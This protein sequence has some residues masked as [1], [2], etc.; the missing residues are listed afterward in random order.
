VRARDSPAV[1]PG[2]VG[3]SARDTF[4]RGKCRRGSS[5]KRAT[6]TLTKRLAT[7][8]CPRRW[9]VH[10]RGQ[11]PATRS[12]EPVS[13]WD[14]HHDDVNAEFR[15]QRDYYDWGDWR[16]GGRGGRRMDFRRMQ[17]AG[18]LGLIVFII[19]GS[20]AARRPPRNG[21]TRGARQIVRR[22]PWAGK[23]HGPAGEIEA[24]HTALR[25]IGVA[26]NT[27]RWADT[28]LR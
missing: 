8:R 22:S 1:L 6:L 25:G 12:M 24:F 15:N 21:N 3:I 16:V 20:N 11:R 17:K 2:I 7:E 27:W 4:T 28:L 14:V 23:R 18:G 26:P 9:P 10:L 19:R 13:S 5:R